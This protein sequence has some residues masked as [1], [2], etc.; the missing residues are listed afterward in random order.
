MAEIKAKS[1]LDSQP[2]NKSLDKMGD[3]VGGFSKQLSKLKG[4][5]GT[6]FVIGGLVKM[7]NN[8]IDLGSKLSDLA[9]ASGLTTDEF[10]A[11]E[12]ALTKAGA[13]SEV[14]QKVFSKINVVLGQAKSGMTTY[15]D[16]FEKIG[17][18]QKEIIDLNPKDVFERLATAVTSAE[19]GSISFGAALEILGA[20]SGAQ[21]IEVLAEINDVGLAGLIKNAKKAG[22][23]IEADLIQ[24]LDLTADAILL[25][26]RSF[27]VF[28]ASMLGLVTKAA[29]G[30]GRVSFIVGE[31]FKRLKSGDVSSLR[32]IN[33]ELRKADTFAAA[34]A[35]KRAAAKKAE[36]EATKAAIEA[37]KV[38]IENAKKGSEAEKKAQVEIDKLRKSIIAKNN[39]AFN[40][41][42]NL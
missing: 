13:K 42:L 36:F 3:K 2:F 21:M 35:L 19:A 28:F 8:I 27:E 12:F 39:A 11:I 17:V 34:A 38:K 32:E 4:T 26:K 14:A 16:L 20:K 18:A 22:Q 25:A 9:T 15:V 33:E 5:I 23:V 31:F 1:S 10:Q 40:V 7:T 29:E 41:L 6:A 30:W 37:E 24:Q